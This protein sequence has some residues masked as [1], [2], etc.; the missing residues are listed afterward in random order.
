MAS[1][2]GSFGGSDLKNVFLNPFLRS[3]PPKK[4]T[5]EFAQQTRQKKLHFILIN[6][7]IDTV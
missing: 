6:I 1:R 4:P 2:I 3:L 5:A 7:A